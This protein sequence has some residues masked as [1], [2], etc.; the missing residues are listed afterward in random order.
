[1]L[2]VSGHA[3]GSFIALSQAPQQV[4]SP[5]ITAAAVSG[6]EVSDV[7]TS[8]VSNV[9]DECSSTLHKGKCI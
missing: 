6:N 8:T 5:V 2:P 4:M 1:M 9:L 3:Q 7:I